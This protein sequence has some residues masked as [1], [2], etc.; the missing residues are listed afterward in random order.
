MAKKIKVSVTDFLEKTLGMSASAESMRMEHTSRR[1]NNEIYSKPMNPYRLAKDLADIQADQYKQHAESVTAYAMSEAAARGYGELSVQDVTDKVTEGAKNA[2]KSFL[3]LIDKLISVIK[4]FIRGL[5]D[6]EKKIAGVI[7]KLK[8]AAKRVSDSSRQDASKEIKVAEL[9]PTIIGFISTDSTSKFDRNGY[10]QALKI[11]E[12]LVGKL[13]KDDRRRLAADYVTEVK[14]G[15]I[16]SGFLRGIIGLLDT[17]KNTRSGGGQNGANIRS[18]IVESIEVARDI[19]KSAKEF[20]VDD[21]RGTDSIKGSYDNTVDIDKIDLKEYKEDWNIIIK[22]FN[23]AQKGIVKAIRSKGTTKADEETANENGY[24]IRKFS[25][26]EDTSNAVKTSL[27]GLVDILTRFKQAKINNSLE[28][29]IKALN[30][31]RQSIIRNKDSRFSNKYAQ[32]GRV[33]IAKLTVLYT[34]SISVMNSIYAAC[35]KVAAVN[36]TAANTLRQKDTNSNNKDTD[37]Y[38][39]NMK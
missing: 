26:S 2:W 38:T 16:A 24:N 17:I 13:G 21:F 33:T 34:K 10:R 4:E 11:G 32:L 27:D 3:V 12:K 22:D 37:D 19:D 6:K 15:T 36:I 5:F 7:K 31:L 23:A 14:K 35:F 30:E 20:G 8:T 9:S 18:F 28:K 39:T 1:R 25:R 29:C